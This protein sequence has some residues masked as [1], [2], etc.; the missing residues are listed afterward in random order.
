MLRFMWAMLPIGLLITACGDPDEPTT[1]RASRGDMSVE[2]G[3][4]PLRVVVR[5][6][7]GAEVLRL[8][9]GEGA[10]GGVAAAV[11]DPDF[12]PQ[13]V[14]G[15][16]GYQARESAYTVAA[17]P[18]LEDIGDDRVTVRF[19]RGLVASLTVRIADRRV[20]FDVQS[21]PLVRHDP[22]GAHTKASIAFR[23]GA[24]EHF[25]GLGQRTATVDHRGW[26]LYNWS[27]EGG[28]GAGE[29]SEPGP[30]N[31]F[32]N[33]VSMTN[34]P[35]PLVHSTAGYS[36]YLDTTY[37]SEF[38]LG[39]ETIDAWRI[40]VN[41][42][43]FAFT[44]YV[45]SDPLENLDLYTQ[46]T[47]RP[48]M[49]APWVFGP[50]RRLS[51]GDTVSGEAEW[52]LLR[53]R[54]VPTTSLD[55]N[56]HFLPDSTHV[57][58]ETELRAWV[59]TLHANGFK[60]MAY[61]NPYVSAS[62]ERAA[63][64]LAYGTDNGLLLRGTDGFVA[65]A[66]LISGSPQSVATI[67]LTVEAGQQWFQS[68][69]KRT[70]DLGYDGWM[71]DFG[72]Y[73][74]RDWVAAD[75]RRGDELHNAFPVLSAKAAHDLLERERPG[76]YHF[77]ARSGFAG[78]QRYVP[79]VWNGD[80]EATFDPTQGLPASLFGG[81]N[82]SMS[83]I[84]YWG[85]DISGFKCYTD[86]PHDKEMYL[87]W[88]QLGAVSP[89][90][91]SQNACANVTGRRPKWTL[92]SDEETIQVYG[93]MARLHTRLQPYFLTL[94]R[95]AH[96]T[97]A[98]LMRHPFLMFPRAPSAWGVTDAFFLGD[99]IYAAP[100][101]RRGDREK[102]VWLPPGNYLHWNS[103]TAYEGNSTITVSAPLAQLPLFLRENRIVPMLDPTIETLAEAT[104]ADVVT[105]SRV[106]DRL[107][108]VVFATGQGASVT[109]EDGTQLSLEM[110]VDADEPAAG[111]FVSVETGALSDC[112]ACFVSESN[113]ASEGRAKRLRI[114]TA[115]ADTADVRFG[116][117]RLAH[118]A[119]RPL[120]V[121]WD[122]YYLD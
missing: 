94:A 67:D 80:P 55:D 91:Q 118:R 82:L 15:W 14:P 119:D 104:V 10:Y 101:V 28:L 70:L 50:R 122:I 58:R 19:R 41:R 92:W 59:D 37:R 7:D 62:N 32:P 68:L 96:E 48:L 60:V 97:G 89:I 107:D 1:W 43:A 8:F 11:D 4:A 66:F 34:F 77:H 115:L 42:N 38:H 22:S 35:V 120:R 44:V 108:A 20:R 46:D 106:R 53:S 88:A 86:D 72:E 100:V 25:F 98:P 71:H 76:D 54:G 112:A 113:P 63:D 36:L 57:G 78:S 49:P 24:D 5:D 31:P 52:R 114:N 84:A 40:A 75:G 81:V 73:V 74:E 64:D 2:V 30:T 102:T 109:L 47:G 27:E 79:A 69:L 61:N 17:A 12:V 87:R 110:G 85:S 111:G 121:R 16:D 117:F 103:G 26:S 3:T 21:E 93:E 23:L 9:D 45:G 33:G 51:L 83:G 90:M 56:V 18:R 116:R 6:R 65:E 105:P 99:A 95:T 13:F 39:S 29:G